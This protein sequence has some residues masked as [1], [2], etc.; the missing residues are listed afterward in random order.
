MDSRITEKIA[1]FKTWQLLSS[2]QEID[3]NPETMC[4]FHLYWKDLQMSESWL[5]SILSLSPPWIEEVDNLIDNLTSS[6]DTAWLPRFSCHY[7]STHWMTYGWHK[8]AV[9]KCIVW[10]IWNQKQLFLS[11]RNTVKEN[12]CCPLL[13][14]VVSICKM[15]KTPNMKSATDSE[16]HS[17]TAKQ[18]SMQKQNRG[19]NLV[20]VVSCI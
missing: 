18:L 12:T 7:C 4:P 17:S 11:L 3:K 8:C 9:D 15:E 5:L 10:H 14:S 2:N 1:Q 13:N 20:M 19:W 16:K 6:A